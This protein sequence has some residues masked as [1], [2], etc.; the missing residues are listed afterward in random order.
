MFCQSNFLMLLG[1]YN[2]HSN[3][4]KRKNEKKINFGALQ[5]CKH[6]KKKHK[7]NLLKQYKGTPEDI[8]TFDL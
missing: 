3:P 1:M 5:K 2:K 6:L 8:K 7:S 4:A